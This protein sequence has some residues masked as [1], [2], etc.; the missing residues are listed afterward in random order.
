MRNRGLP[1]EVVAER[2]NASV[3][4]INEHYDVEDP[5]KEML[6]RRMPYLN[7]LSLDMET[8]ES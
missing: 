2:V 6:K 1:V 4:V 8:T 3:E 5:L 7:N